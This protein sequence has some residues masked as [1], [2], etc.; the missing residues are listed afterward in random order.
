MWD[1]YN[2]IKFSC[3]NI[4]KQCIFFFDFDVNT[5]FTITKS[6]IMSITQRTHTAWRW[7][8][9]SDFRVKATVCYSSASVETRCV[10]SSQQRSLSPELL[11]ITLKA[12]YKDMCDFRLYL[13]LIIITDIGPAGFGKYIFRFSHVWS[14]SHVAVC[15]N[16]GH[17]G[18]GHSYPVQALSDWSKGLMVSLFT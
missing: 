10:A 18:G 4:N 11:T 15:H 7:S 9:D 3:Q 6:K 12:I 17:I 2:L 8:L 14:L 1:E 5:D 16:G 13:R